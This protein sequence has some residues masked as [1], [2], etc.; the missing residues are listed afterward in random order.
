MLFRSR[1]ASGAIAGYATMI[2]LK[3][4]ASELCFLNDGKLIAKY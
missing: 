3:L 1:I 4:P 2:K